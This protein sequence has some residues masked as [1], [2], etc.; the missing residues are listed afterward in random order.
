MVRDCEDLEVVELVEFGCHR[1][2]SFGGLGSLEVLW[3]CPGGDHGH[4]VLLIVE[5]SP[6]VFGG[7]VPGFGEE[8]I[9][10]V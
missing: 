5:I 7:R 3:T 9:S 2:S 4:P 8:N 1:I 10:G 6:W